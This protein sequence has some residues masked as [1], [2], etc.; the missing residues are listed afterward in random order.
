M[1]LSAGTLLNKRYRILSILGTGGMG[2]IYLA[3]D[4]NLKITVAVKENLYLSEEYS[5]QFYREANILAGLRHPNLPRVGDYFTIADQG[6]YLIMDY[7]EG[8]DLRERIERKGALK[9]TEVTLIGAYICDALAFL[10]SRN[11]PV[12]HRDIKPGNIKITP[13]GEVFLVDFGLA[14]IM[15]DSQ[16]T[17]TGARAMTPGYSPPEQYGGSSTDA[18]SDIYS[19]GA[20]LYAALT[21]IIPE[22]GLA[23]ATGKTDLTP[24]NQLE[25]HINRQLARLIEKALSVE[26]QDRFQT[27]EEMKIALVEIGKLEGFTQPRYL[28]APP[29]VA[30]SDVKKEMP[31]DETPSPQFKSPLRGHKLRTA[32]KRPTRPLKRFNWIPALLLLVG[33]VA[34]TFFYLQPNSQRA[35]ANLFPQ[36]L[37][38]AITPTLEHTPQ[39]AALPPLTTPTP[40][41]DKPTEI[42][43]PT[44]TQIPLILPTPTGGGRG[45]IAFASDRTG[46][47]QVWKMN[48]DGSQQKQFTNLIEGACQ[49][50]WSPDGEKLAFISPCGVRRG[51]Y[52]DQ[53]R[54]FFINADGS[55]MQ[56]LPVSEAGDFDPAWAPDGKRIA[57]TS[58]RTGTAHIFVYD[59]ESR[60]LHELS[61]TRFA[62]MHPTWH[63]DG[64]QLAFVRKETFHHVYIMSDQGI[65]QFRFSSSGNVTDLWPDW[66]PDGHFIVFSRSKVSP[67]LPWLLS[68]RYEDRS[69]GRTTRIPPLGAAQFGPIAEARISPDMQWIAFR[70]WPDGRNHDVYLMD[71]NGEERQR[72][73]SDPGYDGM[74]AWR[75]LPAHD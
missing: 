31:G 32:P 1:T 59:F 27:A 61:D 73:T 19:L 2:S 14:K 34:A 68:L 17:T 47:M 55:E 50:H 45:E 33:A 9:D 49:P 52:F 46:T 23:R 15:V 12:I 44:A 24:I 62:D 71:F 4:E 40:S 7:I 53:S 60:T 8:E 25:R 21:G 66:S 37:G 75:P 20:T 72:L 43:A 70:G 48:S 63:I 64:K 42:V 58:L 5:R 3:E 57:F 22:D 26:P 69:T 74:P 35:L 41:T 39:N 16:S 10:H 6:Q 11:P 65:T 36:L 18:R 67:L 56:M 38:Q 54:I 30:S 28:V 13:E 51:F 29:P